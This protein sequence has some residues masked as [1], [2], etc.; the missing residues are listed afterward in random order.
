MCVLPHKN[1]SVLFRHIIPALMSKFSIFF[2]L[3]LSLLFLSDVL[4]YVIVIFEMLL[5]RKENKKS[6][7]SCHGLIYDLDMHQILVSFAF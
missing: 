2:R 5:T 6:K 4:Q 1:T 7:Q 3:T